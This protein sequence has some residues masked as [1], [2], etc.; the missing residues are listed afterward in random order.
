MAASDDNEQRTAAI[1]IRVKPSV[2]AE[3]ERLAKAQHRPLSN[4][5]QVLLEEHIEAKK[6]EAKKKGKG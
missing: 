4:Y 1:G 3:L 6:Q 5:L 2:K